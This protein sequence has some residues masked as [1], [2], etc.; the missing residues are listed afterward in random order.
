[1]RFKVVGH[2]TCILLFNPAEVSCGIPPN[3]SFTETP[4]SILRYSDV[5]NYSCISGYGT[6]QPI[7]TQCQADGTF[8]L[9]DPPS[10]SSKSDFDL[11]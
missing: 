5:Y 6:N 10:C 8:S 1:M 7:M 11:L 4:Q 2:I 3:G 9:K